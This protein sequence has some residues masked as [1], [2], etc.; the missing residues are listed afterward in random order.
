MTQAFALS[1]ESR[2]GDE[3]LSNYSFRCLTEETAE[4]DRERGLCMAKRRNGQAPLIFD[5]PT[6]LVH[7]KSCDQVHTW[8]KCEHPFIWNLA[9]PNP[10]LFTGTTWKPQ[11]PI[12]QQIVSC[13]LRVRAPMNNSTCC[14]R[15]HNA[16]AQGSYSRPGSFEDR[17]LKALEERLK[18]REI[19]HM[20]TKEERKG[21]EDFVRKRLEHSKP[22][23]HEHIKELETKVAASK[24]QR[25][26]DILEALIAHDQQ[27]LDKFSLHKTPP[28]HA[29]ANTR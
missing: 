6:T 11:E 9:W 13:S 3:P 15:V 28:S 21:Y 4:P 20:L 29:F 23:I 12:P 10:A 27:L 25:D 19:P 17:R 5:L 16:L 24:A 26:R 8:R 18:G 22:S 1:Q 14:E 2:T 7:Q